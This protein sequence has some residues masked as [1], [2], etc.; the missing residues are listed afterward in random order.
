MD[1]TLLLIGGSNID[2][3][4]TSKNKLIKKVSNVGTI[5][6]SFGGVMRNIAENLARLGNKVD[7]LTAIGSDANGKAMKE[8]LESLGINVISPTSIFPSGS[9][10]AINDSNHDMVEG[11]CDNRIIS[12]LN[13]DFIKA[14]NEIISTHEYIIIDSNL[15]ETTIDY[16]FATYPNK[17]FIVEAIS[18]TKVLKYK[19]NLDK[20]YL[21]KC[22]IH[23]ARMLMG[24]D[25]IE[26]DL[27]GGLLARGV[28]NVVVSHGAHNI[29]FGHDVRKIDLVEVQEVL[30]FENTTGC[31]DAL[32]S[33]V[34]DHFLR[35][36]TLKE[37]V[38]FGHELSRLTLM[39]KSATSKE[40]D[41]YRHN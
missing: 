29:Y 33:G 21:I 4:A 7:F 9:Y 2:Y 26:K 25:L 27:V 8:D 3:I 24:I 13:I 19:K 35:G 1:K 22:N 38:A 6:I 11:I 10:V 40:I 37:S 36:Y 23:E 32:T 34:I 30:D 31:G 15:D 20:I 12:D 16:L 5:S 17:K 18:P 39:S 14:N 41:K 28:K